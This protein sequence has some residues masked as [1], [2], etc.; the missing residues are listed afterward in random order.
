MSPV[1]LA[2]DTMLFS[3]L[4]N[5]SISPSVSE[6]VNIAIAVTVKSPSSCSP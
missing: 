1:S 4:Q 5:R 3:E 6:V 2:V